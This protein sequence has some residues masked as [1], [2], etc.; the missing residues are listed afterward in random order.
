MAQKQGGGSSSALVAAGG[1]P[2]QTVKRP[3]Q[4]LAQK[5]RF[6]DPD[7]DLFFVA[8]LGWGPAGGLDIGQAFHV[9]AQIID[10]DAE[11]WVAAFSGYGDA[12]NA[13][14]EA[15][16][17]RGWLRQAGEA[18][19][20][21]FAS[22]RSS[23]Q[24]AALGPA[25]TSLYAKHKAAFLVATQELAL[26]ATFFATPYRDR[27][28]PGVYF[29]HPDPD[30]PVVLIIGGADT[31]FEDLFL[32]VGRN[33]L[34]RGYSVALAD[35]PGQGSLAADG[36][37]WEVDAE[38]PIGALI[39]TL[40]D[41]FGAKPGRIAL[42][43]LSLGGYFVTRAAGLEQRLSAVVASTP[44]PNPGE[45]FRLSVQAAS[46]RRTSSPP[47]GPARRSRQILLWKAGAE[48][49]EM[50]LERTKNMVADPARVTVP[51][52]SIVGEGDS[53]LFVAQAEAWH[54]AIRSDRKSLVR[55]DAATGAD[56]H[57]QIN[58]RLRLA[59]E[60]AGWLGEIFA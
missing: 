50:L 28:L 48:T 25:F 16:K 54:G 23:W 40:I 52:L 47:D 22:Y 60:T 15:W 5:Y 1:R 27:T 55:L 20:K 59:Q 41:R 12:M 3:D 13:Q 45:M 49:P 30:A 7:M 38:K 36:L 17:H 57:C 24:F 8:A 33:M 32:T 56:G 42:L 9:A 53:P 44:F 11:S 34:E 4:R 35:L 43:G 19:L 51:F 39:D 46:A 14:A 18:R 10:G 29:R 21:A 58:N 2:E 6:D 26:P 31:C 37:H